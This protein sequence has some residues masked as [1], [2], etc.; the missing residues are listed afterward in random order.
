MV[1]GAALLDRR[2]PHFCSGV[3]NGPPTDAK[4]GRGICVKPIGERGYHD[5]LSASAHLH[6]RPLA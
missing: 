5:G 4:F 6:P 3:Y 1:V 2:P